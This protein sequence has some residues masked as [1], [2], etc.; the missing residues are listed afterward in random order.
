VRH[1]LPRIT[2]R[3]RAAG[4]NKPT[5]A[6]RVALLAQCASAL[7]LLTCQ[8]LLFASAHLCRNLGGDW[9]G[10]LQAGVS[11]EL[12]KN[13]LTGTIPAGIGS[14]A[15][16]QDLCVLT[17]PFCD[18]CSCDAARPS[19]SSQ[20]GANELIGTV[21]SNLGALT[22]LTWMCV[23]DP[24]ACFLCGAVLKTVRALMAAGRVVSQWCT[25]EKTGSPARYR[26]CSDLF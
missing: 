8:P 21:P 14:L 18:T 17:T 20:L 6:R 12:V 9:W 13:R 1:F 24:R 26:T 3:Q 10:S 15:N 2:R 22:L 16:L 5:F 11:S 23:H 7:Q 19:I 4:Y 25:F